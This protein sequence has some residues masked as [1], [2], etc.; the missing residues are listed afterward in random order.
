MNYPEITTRAAP[1]FWVQQFNSP[2]GEFLALGSDQEASMGLFH[3]DYK[4]DP[5]EWGD[6]R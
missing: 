6:A 3:Q 4:D 1:I 2:A 5:N